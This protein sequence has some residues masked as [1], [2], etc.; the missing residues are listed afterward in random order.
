[1]AA[2]YTPLNPFGLRLF[3][4]ARCTADTPR[5]GLQEMRHG[6]SAVRLGT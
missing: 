2:Q 1:M 6:Q 4:R 5:D 3:S